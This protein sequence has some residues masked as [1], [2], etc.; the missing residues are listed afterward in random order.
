MILN[1]AKE[2]LKKAFDL[3]DRDIAYIEYYSLAEQNRFINFIV[4]NLKMD[5]KKHFVISH[6]LRYIVYRL[7]ELYNIGGGDGKWLIKELF[8]S[9]VVNK[10]N[11]IPVNKLGK[12]F[13]DSVESMNNIPEI[14]NKL[15]LPK[16]KE[17]K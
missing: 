10:A 4:K 9:Y 1:V 8:H 16:I 2:I 17:E 7:G 6:I 3:S 12:T 5:V 14:L 13:V 11:A 15:K